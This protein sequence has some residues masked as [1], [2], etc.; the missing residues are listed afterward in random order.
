MY[1]MGAEN[2][3]V[4]IVQD[5]RE[6]SRDWTEILECEGIGRVGR[7]RSVEEA[8]WCLRECKPYAVLLDLNI[9]WK[10]DEPEEKR[11]LR[12]FGGFEV[13]RR[14]AVAGF[15][16]SRIIVT[17]GYIEISAQLELKALGV[18]WFLQAP[19]TPEQLAYSVCTLL[20][21]PETPEKPAAL[22]FIKAAPYV[23]GLAKPG[24]L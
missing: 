23:L 22:K 5:D 11:Y 20:N 7:C 12:E 2:Y 18:Q 17:S 24:F 19:C 4:L 9:Y 6:L 1:S 10:E 15:D 3:S 21:R 13:A 14:A 8:T 16:M